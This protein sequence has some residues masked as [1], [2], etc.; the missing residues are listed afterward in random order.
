MSDRRQRL[1]CDGLP[2]TMSVH[3]ANP[4]NTDSIIM[5]CSFN[6]DHVLQAAQSFVGLK[7]LN[8]RGSE[9][10]PL[11][12]AHHLHAKYSFASGHTGSGS[13]Y[14]SQ[15][16]CPPDS[17]WKSGA[18]D[19]HD[20]VLAFTNTTLSLFQIHLRPAS[21]DRTEAVLHMI[22]PSW[23]YDKASCFSL[24]S[25]RLHPFLTLHPPS[26]ILDSPAPFHTYYTFW[27]PAS[28]LLRSRPTS[29]IP[30]LRILNPCLSR[31]SARQEP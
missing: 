14:S 7:P 13:S 31:A 30:Q 15:Q 21:Q 29:W 8:F 19:F 17:R 24:P 20:S 27:K 18:G 26:T 28:T 10:L 25:F 1:S 23:P 4:V 9:P 6:Y 5:V 16:L 11:T 2:A 3:S 22:S 12:S